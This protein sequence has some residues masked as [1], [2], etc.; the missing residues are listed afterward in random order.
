MIIF[1]RDVLEGCSLNA[2]QMLA[3]YYQ[4]EYNNCT[5]DMLVD[6]LE[7]AFLK[8]HYKDESQEAQELGVSVQIL[9]I[10]KSQEK[11]NV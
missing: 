10:R 5:K 4:V 2:L 6:S 9:R 1:T 7:K 3:Q 8:L 11:L